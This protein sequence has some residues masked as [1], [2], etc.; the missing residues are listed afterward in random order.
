MSYLAHAVLDALRSDFV[1]DTVPYAVIALQGGD[2]GPLPLCIVL[3][4]GGGSRQG[5][6]DDSNNINFC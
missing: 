1:P 5:L 6:V 3:H 4:G 2:P